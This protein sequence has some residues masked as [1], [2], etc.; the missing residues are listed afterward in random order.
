MRELLDTAKALNDATRLR[1]LL[2]LEGGELCLCQLIAL[3]DLAPS[4]ISKH[5][6]LLERAGLVARR[7]AGR[8]QY[9]RL[10]GAEAPPM[11]RKALRWVLEALRERPGASADAARIRK[12]RRA[13]M[14]VLC[15]RYRG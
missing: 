1:A 5:M 15:R 6:A 8:W 12:V 11:A 9:F 2:A 7:K 14:E 13:N 4:T 3:F 10:A